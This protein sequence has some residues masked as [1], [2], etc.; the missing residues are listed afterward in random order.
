MPV[1]PS[2]ASGARAGG[3]MTQQADA[4]WNAPGGAD[5]FLQWDKMHAPRPQTQLTEDIFIACLSEGF[6]AGM[7]EYSCPAGMRYQ[8]INR[9]G[10]SEI[11]MFEA[12]GTPAFDQRVEAY[13]AKLQDIL[14][15]MGDIWVNEWL[16]R[17]MPGLERARDT[18]FTTMRSSPSSTR[19]WTSSAT[20]TRSTAC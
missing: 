17:I 14:P 3:L 2:A 4:V 9:Y 11:T 18:D 12:P 5:Q 6:A 16:P 13:Q 7:N 19:C 8:I 1:T 10:F 20:A 15:R